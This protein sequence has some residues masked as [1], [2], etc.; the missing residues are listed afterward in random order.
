MALRKAETAKSEYELFSEYKCTKDKSLRAEIIES[1]IYIAEILSRRFINRGIDYEDI[2]QVACMGIIK[3]VD[4]F[5]LDKGVKFV[6]Y[7]TPTVLGEIRKYFRDKGAFIK[8]PRKLYEM[9]Y[10][11][12]QIRRSY[13][14]SNGECSLKEAARIL[15][16]S[17][18]TIA[19]LERIGDAVFIRS[20]EQEAFCDGN[21][22][23]A[24]VVGVE[25]E[26][27]L[28]IE[29]RDFMDYLISQ[30]SKEERRF[31][32]LRYNKNMTQSQISEILGVSQM[33]VSRMEKKILK[34]L[35]DL[36]FHE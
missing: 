13:A 26:H 28:M 34:K 9:F 16:L 1:Y 23:A 3:A 24:N 27:F 19:D 35:R 31:I 29:N 25:D 32:N 2:Y 8:I 18:G 11:A 6:T 10:K 4:R 17:E 12:E 33:N 14:K 30:L 20:I 7:A 22:T 15:N 21:A 5:D 36:Y